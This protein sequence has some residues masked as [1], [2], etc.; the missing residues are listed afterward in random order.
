MKVIICDYCGKFPWTS[1]VLDSNYYQSE[2]I[3]LT[4]C[5]ECGS[6]Y[7]DV[8]INGGPYRD[9]FE[10]IEECCIID[11]KKRKESK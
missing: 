6:D 3:F 7:C 4:K 5:G 2:D 9:D 8:C 1:K 11:Y 10:M